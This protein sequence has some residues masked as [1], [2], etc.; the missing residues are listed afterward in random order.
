MAK[1]KKLISKEDAK[2]LI[3]IEHTLLVDGCPF[4]K[5]SDDIYADRVSEVTTDFCVL[6]VTCVACEKSWSVN[7]MLDYFVEEEG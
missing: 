4:C 3:D 1:K 2:R 5:T 7:Y 6:D